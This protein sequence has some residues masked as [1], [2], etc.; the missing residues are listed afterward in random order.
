MNENS[1]FVVFSI[2]SVCVDML[3]SWPYISYFLFGTKV[4]YTFDASW[5]L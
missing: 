3:V 5:K 1:V 2:V 4:G